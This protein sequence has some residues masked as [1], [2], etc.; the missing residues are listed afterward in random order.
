MKII[1][2]ND[3]SGFLFFRFQGFRIY[4]SSIQKPV[5]HSV[6]ITGEKF[7]LANSRNTEYIYGL[8]VFIRTLHTAE[9]PDR[10]DVTQPLF[11][12]C[13]HSFRPLPDTLIYGI[14]QTKPGEGLWLDYNS[15]SVFCTLTE[16]LVQHFEN[17]RTIHAGCRFD[18]RQ[19]NGLVISK[20]L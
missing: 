8:T 19:V 5:F 6:Q 14:P 3:L 7:G 9:R 17:N 1:D 16:W 12:C 20:T 18:C 11:L 2:D 4:F 15:Q 13:F 10:A